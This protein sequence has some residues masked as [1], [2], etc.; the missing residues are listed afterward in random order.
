MNELTWNEAILRVL[1]DAG[2]PLHVEELTQRIL[3]S[4]LRTT[5]GA[6]PR[7]TVSHCI[8]SSLKADGDESPFIRTARAVYGLRGS[9]LSDGHSFD[10]QNASLDLS[11]E[12]AAESE[13]VGLV[14]AFGM[15]WQRE[16]VN[17][18]SRST[19][20][21]G[22]Q[23]IQASSVDFSSQLGVYLLHDGRE[24]IYVGRSTERPMG[25]R[26]FEHTKDRLQTRWNRF[27]WFGLLKV[28]DQGEL[29]PADAQLTTELVA[30]TLEAV[31]IEGL[32]PRQNRKRGDGFNATEYLQAE[33]PEIERRQ[34]QIFLDSLE[35]KL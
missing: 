29:V 15:Y 16:A 26:L 13:D 24:V 3:D 22:R 27:S 34:A 8:T 18:A 6:T 33:D 19:V 23:K 28:T 21:L 25:E 11:D 10:A 30:T 5:V 20:I 14:Q 17:W 32:E 4:Q 9:L 12:E 35:A 2:Q 7:H 31:L 1:A